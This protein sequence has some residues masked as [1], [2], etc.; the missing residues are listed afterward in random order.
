[1]ET[2]TLGRELLLVAVLATAARSVPLPAR[3]EAAEGTASPAAPPRTDGRLPAGVQPLGYALELTLDPALPRFSGRAR[4]K[5][6]IAEPTR[7]IVLHAKELDVRRAT[8]RTPQ[9]ERAATPTLR[10]A[11]GSKTEREELVLSF[12]APV[13]AGE[14]ELDLTYEGAFGDKMRGLYHVQERG[15]WYAFTQFEATNM[16]AGWR[17][18]SSVAGAVT[19]HM[20]WWEW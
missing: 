16:H 1:M 13:G 18:Q 6:R 11:A 2:R 7:A 9:G 17:A 20:H 4:I 5:V 15:T 8:L 12:D 3:A 19:G 10:K 14:A